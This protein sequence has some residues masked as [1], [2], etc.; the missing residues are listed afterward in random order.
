VKGMVKG[1]I[2]VKRMS[3]F[4]DIIREIGQYFDKGFSTLDNEQASYNF[5]ARYGLFYFDGTWN[6]YS[7]K[8]NAS[9]DV[10][11][12]RIPVLGAGHPHSRYFS[13]HIT[14]VN[15][16]TGGKFGIPKASKHF[17]LALELLQFMTSYEI[18]QMI[19]RHCKFPPVVKFARYEGLLKSVKPQ[20]DG[21]SLIQ[22]PFCDGSWKS[23]SQQWLFETLEDIIKK[24]S[25]DAQEYFIKEFKKSVK[26]PIHG[27]NEQL[28]ALNRSIIKTEMKRSQIAL[29][30]LRNDLTDQ[31]R[32]GLF[33]RQKI[34]M[35]LFSRNVK[36]YF[37]NIDFI[38]YL[39]KLSAQ[40]KDEK[41]L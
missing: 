27:L 34:S 40:E 17:D 33:L 7:I 18:N 10:G 29:G 26:I 20:L 41:A 39:K 31:A 35:E 15:S 6:L 1:T 9:F 32:T 4:V 12:L 25:P 2:P 19:M 37:Y 22:P 28:K 8:N 30:L 21:N 24:N 13:G 11:V 3:V 36:R 14:E 38:E 23:A 5:Y 16:K